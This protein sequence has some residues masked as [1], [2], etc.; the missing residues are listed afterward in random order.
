MTIAHEVKLVVWDLDDTFWQ[1]TLSEEAITPI[2][3][4]SELVRL[5][6]SR[7][8]VSSICSKNEKSAVEM[9]LR[10]LDIWDYF[11]LPSVSFAA[12]GRAIAELVEALQLRA[13]NVIFID[14]N[15]SVRAEAAFGCPGLQCLASPDELRA[16][17]DSPHLRG[18]PD[19]D[20]TR[21]AQYRALSDRFDRRQNHA[22]GNEDFL[23]Q[24]EIRI[25]IDYAVEEHLDRVVEMINRSNQL[26]FTKR[27][28]PGAEARA[29]FVAELSRFGFKAGVVRASDKYGDYG[30][31][32]FFMT[33]A[34]LKTYRLEHFVFSCRI[35]N[36]GIEQYVYEY[37]KKPEIEIAAP[38]ANGLAAYPRVDW[39]EFGSAVRSADHLRDREIVLIGGCDMLQLSTYC[40]G[41]SREFT[42]REHRGII[43]RLDDPFILL[44]DS[45]A[46]AA[47]PLRGEIPAFDFEDLIELRD[48]LAQADAVIVSLYRMMEI[49]YFRGRDGLT[50]RL[51]E[52]AVREILASDRGLWFVRNFGFVEFTHEQRQELVRLSLARL[53]EMTPADCRVIVL[54]ENTRKLEANPNEKRL[55][56]IYNQFLI[57][58]SQVL[59]RMDYIDVNVE[60]HIDWLFDDGF[61]MSRQGYFEL[62]QAVRARLA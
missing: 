16:A 56:E 9:Q 40:G 18:K 62:A 20:L 4:N 21:L 17:L 28:L 55:R 48:A 37:L 44:D 32:G 33:L 27:R 49:N 34:T 42:N 24:S 35:M 36:M 12:K 26:N 30:V 50:V 57:D 22:A 54:L 38:V 8:I 25:E 46:V 3:A 47:S 14:D 51:D 15:A 53:V 31:V 23:R 60:T 6:A 13:E 45:E 1:G 7:G 58:Q 41:R 10:A 43:K 59:D 52:D 11:V 39:I 29:E 19:P 5:L 2:A 61:H